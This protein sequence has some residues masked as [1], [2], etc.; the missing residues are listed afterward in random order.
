MRKVPRVVLGK[1]GLDSHDTGMRL[2]SSLL[3]NA[4]YEVIYAGLF[5][6]PE[7]LVKAA[8]D[9]DV[10]VVGLSFHSGG[11]VEKVHRVLELLAKKKA[12]I[13]LVVGGVIVQDDIPKLKAMG[14]REVFVP[15][16]SADDII[17]FFRG[18]FGGGHQA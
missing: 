5:N 18:A 4:G 2:V 13:P 17:R 9:E 1:I 6:T 3:R 15:G 11:Q 16:S 10:D 7:T 14:V 8:I 12:N